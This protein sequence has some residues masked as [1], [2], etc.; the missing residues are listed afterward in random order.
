MALSHQK[1]AGLLLLLVLA[2][3]GF[4]FAMVPL[5]DVF[6][7][8]TG[9]NG[10]IRTPTQQSEITVVQQATP[11]ESAK[12]FHV[13]HLVTVEFVS[14]VANG[15]TVDFVPQY[16]QLQI[17]PGQQAY[18]THFTVTNLSD[19]PLKLQAVPSVTPGIANQYLHKVV[20]FCFE[21][22][23]L[24]AGEQKTMDLSFRVDAELPD[25]IKRLSLAYTLYPQ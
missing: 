9:L 2:M 16:T 25:E 23:T 21:Q 8:I 13:E 20:C 24:E 22:Q 4:G 6:C 10:R 14:H 3:F 15:L 17:T 12:M 19:Q 1:L 11:T 18:Q 5:Y 7:Q